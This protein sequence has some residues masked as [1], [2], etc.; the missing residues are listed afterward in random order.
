MARRPCAA[1]APPAAL[2]APS[3]QTTNKYRGVTRSWSG[4]DAAIAH[5]LHVAM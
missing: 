1:S 4:N 2:A 5:E 3:K